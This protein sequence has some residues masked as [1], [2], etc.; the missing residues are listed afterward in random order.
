M[1]MS[2]LTLT[3]VALV[4]SSMTAA[5]A[6]NYATTSRSIGASIVT[7]NGAAY[8]SIETSDASYT[9][10][11]AWTDG[12]LDVT[13]DGGTSC[14]GTA[15]GTG[16]NPDS[17]YYFSDVIKITNK[18][19]KDLT[20]LWLNFTDD[21]IQSKTATSAG[22]NMATTS[23]WARENAVGALTVGSSVYVSF[24][25]DTDTT[26]LDTSDGAQTKSMTIHARA[27]N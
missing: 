3:V 19:R 23:G 21:I 10:M 13:F 9:C 6:F 18:G 4:A 17:I 7:D 12:K 16:V 5:S 25:V 27:T 11:L 26:N 22:T 14:S 15:P 8:I 1:R 24:K 20:G 2:F